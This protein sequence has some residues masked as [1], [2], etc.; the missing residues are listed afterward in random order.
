[1]KGS[2]LYNAYGAREPSHKTNRVIAVEGYVDVIAMVMAGIGETVAPLG[3][4]RT[5]GQL[6]LLWRMA[7]DQILLFDGD[8]AGR[9]AAYRAV[10]IAL[11][12][13]K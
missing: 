12:H 4:A 11:P 10:D 2:L 8:K 13:L 6:E 5:E 7:P 9:R 1:H 3:T